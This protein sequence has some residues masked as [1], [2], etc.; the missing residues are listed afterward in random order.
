MWS[1]PRQPPR[2]ICDRG[3][4]DDG[5]GREDR[6]QCGVGILGTI[7][8]TWFDLDPPW[9]QVLAT[10][11]AK[12][13]A[14]EAVAG[15]LNTSTTANRSKWLFR[16]EQ[17]VNSTLRR[18]S[19][20]PR[21]TL[22]PGVKGGRGVQAR[23][24]TPQLPASCSLGGVSRVESRYSTLGLTAPACVTAVATRREHIPA[25]DVDGVSGRI[26]PR[27]AQVPG[28]VLPCVVANSRRHRCFLPPFVRR[29]EKEQGKAFALP[30]LLP[31]WSPDTATNAPPTARGVSRARR[32]RFHVCVLAKSYPPIRCALSIQ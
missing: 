8:A 5:D 29:Q 13:A 19:R 18:A 14:S 23:P 3:S 10:V 28:N 7:V 31:A 27:P 2:P 20:L 21:S 26:G 32:T 15:S 22:G 11:G 1:R 17:P 9:P 6:D 24:A 25:L 30:F 16:A 12:M 4:D